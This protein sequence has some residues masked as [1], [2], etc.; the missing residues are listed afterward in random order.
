MPEV[1]A[2]SAAAKGGVPHLTMRILTRARAPLTSG[3]PRHG[4]RAA[5]RPRLHQ[6]TGCRR[7]RLSACHQ[8]CSRSLLRMPT[9]NSLASAQLT[10]RCEF[11]WTMLPRTTEKMTATGFDPWRTQ[12][13]CSASRHAAEVSHLCTDQEPTREFLQQSPRRC[14]GPAL[15]TDQHSRRLTDKLQILS[16]N[17]GPARG[18][19]STR[20]GKPRQR[21]PQHMIC[22]Q[23]GAHFGPPVPSRRTSVS[24]PNTFPCTPIQVPC[25]LKY[26]SWAVEGM[27]VTANFAK[28]PTRRPP[29][30]RSPTSTSTTN[31]PYG[32][33]SV[34]RVHCSSAI[35]LRNSM[36]S[37]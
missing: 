17:P 30:P 27:V 22:F 12:L 36:Q 2:P 33:P 31:A 34:L 13:S 29:T 10:E 26:S 15:G 5:L 19:R 37:S 4:V 25:S 24:P 18:F 35:F 8:G 14:H 1:S 11:V 6:M 20:F 28:R 7:P 16:W 23:A 32:G 21:T 9:A 3:F